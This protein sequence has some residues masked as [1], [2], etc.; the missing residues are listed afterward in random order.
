MMTIIASMTHLAVAK[1]VKANVALRLQQRCD[2]DRFPRHAPNLE[3]QDADA[4]RLDRHRDDRNEGAGM[5]FRSAQV[6]RREHA[7]ADDG[8]RQKCC[9]NETQDQGKTKLPAISGI[10]DRRHATIVDVREASNCN[11]H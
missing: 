2:G 8:H 4:C 3:S 9:R 11:S 1:N 6:E 10:E 5:K 7:L